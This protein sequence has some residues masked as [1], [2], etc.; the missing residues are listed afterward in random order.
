M[1]AA[2]RALKEEAA[3]GGE[4]YGAEIGRGGASGIN[5]LNSKQSKVPEGVL[6]VN[7]SR[8]KK[9]FG[10]LLP[11]KDGRVSFS[12]LVKFCKLTKIFPDLVSM[13]ELKKIA[14]KF[15]SSAKLS[16]SQFEQTL[17]L[18]A[19]SFFTDSNATER[20]KQLIRHIKNPCKAVFGVALMIHY[21]EA[22]ELGL[23]SSL[24]RPKSVAE[25]VHKRD[26]SMKIDI[27]ISAAL[28]ALKSPRSIARRSPSGLSGRASPSEGI[29]TN[30]TPSSKKILTLREDSMATRRVLSQPATSRNQAK[31]SFKLDPKSL[32]LLQEKVELSDFIETERTIKAD[33]IFVRT[34]RRAV[35]RPPLV[36]PLTILSMSSNENQTARKLRTPSGKYTTADALLSRIISKFESFKSKH[37][38]IVS[39]ARL[40]KRSSVKSTEV[41]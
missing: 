8:L 39:S 3:K 10:K 20:V 26:D 14:G 2:K 4:L 7:R 17:K 30:R 24:L 22:M 38:S 1:S 11:D 9:V 5:M 12:E 35:T 40:S 29:K 36:P 31:S 34:P 15:G 19:T 6:D 23:K 27:D 21:D 25:I 32:K 41:V 18:I 33:P 16:F 37:Y 28:E 13:A